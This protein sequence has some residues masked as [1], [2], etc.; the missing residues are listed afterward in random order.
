MIQ[1]TNK[2]NIQIDLMS[3]EKKILKN[4][5]ENQEDIADRI[6]KLT[7]KK[8]AVKEMI[9]DI[10]SIDALK[11]CL[12]YVLAIP[13]CIL[14]VL[15]VFYA[16]CVAFFGVALWVPFTIESLSKWEALAVAFGMPVGIAFSV[17]IF[18]PIHNWVYG[19][20][21]NGLDYAMIPMVIPILLIAFNL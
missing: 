12:R 8:V 11:V 13:E 7:S 9:M 20:N 10:F 17:F 21:K 4:I 1:D 15:V 16:A 5:K 14:I 2:E 19:E 18:M 3:A 6:N